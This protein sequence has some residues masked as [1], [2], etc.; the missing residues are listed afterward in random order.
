MRVEVVVVTVSGSTDGSLAVWRLKDETE[1]AAGYQCLS[2]FL[3]QRRSFAESFSAL[4][5][6]LTKP[7]NFIYL[8]HNYI[9]S[10]ES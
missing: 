10:E 5:E 3:P 7:T 4:A 2:V 1:E 8:Q 6:S 9:L